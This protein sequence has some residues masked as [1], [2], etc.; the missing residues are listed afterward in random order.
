ML[1]KSEKIFNKIFTIPI[2][3]KMGLIFSIHKP[4]EKENPN[5]FHGI[6]L[7]DS[8]GKLFNTISH[9]KLSTKFQNTSTLSPAQAGLCKDRRTSDHS[10]LVAK[11][12]YLYAL[13]TFR[14]LTIQYRQMD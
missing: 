8:L 12:K 1:V 4:G 5:N 14:K 13:L 3:E 10:M 6:T 7:S 11:S 9:N 2:L